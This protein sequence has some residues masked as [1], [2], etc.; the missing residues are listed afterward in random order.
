MDDL[1]LD[2]LNLDDLDAGKSAGGS[3][4]RGGGEKRARRPKRFLIFLAGLAVGVAGTLLVPRYL[5]PYLPDS[6]TRESQIVQGPVDGKRLEGDESPR[7]LLTVRGEQGAVLATFT[8]RVA[9]IDLLVAEGD[10]ITLG[11]A[12]YRPFIENP[13]VRGVRK[14]APGAGRSRTTEEPAA[15][16]DEAPPGGSP[17][18]DPVAPDSASRGAGTTG[19]EP[20]PDTA[21]SQADGAA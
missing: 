5:R 10:T 14:A 19:G 13:E 15:G 8:R 6:L 1:N 18:S 11:V 2:D 12:E 17:R 16:A 21:S 4:G 20:A 3:G 7:L 9:E